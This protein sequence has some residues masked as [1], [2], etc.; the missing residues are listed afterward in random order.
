LAI[1]LSGQRFFSV[2]GILQPMCA[3]LGMVS[4]RGLARLFRE[5]Y[6]PWVFWP[7]C[8]LLV[9]QSVVNIGADLGKMASAVGMI[10]GLRP[11]Y[12]TFLF[13][14]TIVLLL[15]ARPHRRIASLVKLY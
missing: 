12:F 5:R 1:L 7:S 8:L 15:A 4:G 9:V 14:G 2:N 3:R 6:R 13:A 11:D 10:T